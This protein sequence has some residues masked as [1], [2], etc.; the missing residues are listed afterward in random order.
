[1]CTSRVLFHPDDWSGPLISFRYLYY[2]CTALG[3]VICF[4]P[5]VTRAPPY[6]L[7][8]IALTRSAYTVFIFVL[9]VRQRVSRVRSVLLV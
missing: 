7:L 5:A 1:M 6:I 9:V 2:G 3:V 8:S 4:I